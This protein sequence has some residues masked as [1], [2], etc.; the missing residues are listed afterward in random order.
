LLAPVEKPLLRVPIEL[1]RPIA[2]KVAHIG[3]ACPRGP[4]F[5]RRDLRPARASEPLAQVV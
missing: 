3:D 5:L 2:G 1:V 4:R